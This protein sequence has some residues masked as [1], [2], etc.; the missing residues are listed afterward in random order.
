MYVCIFMHLS[1]YEEKEPGRASLLWRFV[2]L[3]LPPIEVNRYDLSSGSEQKSYREKILNIHLDP[4]Y[5]RRS[6]H[7]IQLSEREIHSPQEIH[8]LPRTYRYTHSSM[9]TKKPSSQQLNWPYSRT[10]L[11]TYTHLD[12]YAQ[13]YIRPHWLMYCPSPQ[14]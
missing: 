3:H 4:S 8:T 12:V 2:S 1:V 14:A 6:L 10:Y 13:V 5:A 9:Q 7:A 11:Y